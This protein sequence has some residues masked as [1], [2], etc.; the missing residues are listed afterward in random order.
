MP[1]T[2]SAPQRLLLVDYENRTRIDLSQLDASWRALIFVGA[3]QNPPKDSR[4]PSTKHRFTRV[5]FHQI[6]GT[7]KNAL[8]FHIAFHLGRTFETAPQT[9]CYVLTGDKG[10]D[11]LLAYLNKNGLRCTRVETFHELIPKPDGATCV[12]CSRFCTLEHLGSYWCS[13]CGHFATPPDPKDLL[14][15]QPR[16]REAAKTKV[17]HAQPLK[18]LCGWCHQ[19]MDMGDGIYDDGEWMCGGC[20]SHYAR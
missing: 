16:H 5:D 9:E 13:D 12:R 11:P 17:Y 14:S 3:K 18:H 19:P 7:G 10:F 6:E 2:P 1:D 4:K 15:N 20:I 8:D